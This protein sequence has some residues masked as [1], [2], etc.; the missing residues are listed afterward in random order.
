MIEILPIDFLG[1]G[2]LLEP[3]D[4]KLHDLAIDYCHRELRAGKSVD[5]S[6]LAKTWV[7]L[8]DGEVFGVAGYVLKADIPLFRGTDVEVMRALGQRMNAYFADN[9]ARGREVFMYIGDEPPKERCPAW[10]Q[11]LKEFGAQSAR[12]VLFE[13]K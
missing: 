4:R 13:V 10:R 6:K 3:A 8:K 9:G 12:R 5:F 1:Q 2:A 7:G 11:V